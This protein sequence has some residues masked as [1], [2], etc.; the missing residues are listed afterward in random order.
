VLVAYLLIATAAYAVD[1]INKSSTAPPTLQAPGQPAPPARAPAPAPADRSWWRYLDPIEL[2]ADVNGKASVSKLQILFFSI[3]VFGL[4]SYIVM[5]TGVLSDLSPSIL[6]LLGISAVGAAA[7]KATE[8]SR[9]RLDFDNWAWLIRKGWLPPGGLCAVSQAR[10]RDLVTPDGEFSVYNFQM[11]IFSLVVGGALLTTGL[12][13]LASF[14]VPDTLLGVLG[15]SQA[16]Y[17]S[18]KL[19]APPSFKELND[20]VSRLRKLEAD[21]VEAAAI[22]LDPDVTAPQPP[23]PPADLQ[24]AKRRAG[25]VVGGKDRTTYKKYKEE[26]ANTRIMFK[27]IF[28]REV[29]DLQLEPSFV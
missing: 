6:L 26:A 16:V 23:M 20:A 27:S 22:T 19:V 13:D 8:V 28:S 2:C 15:L 3:I 11:L 17:V 25:N 21:F 10:W 29:T 7:S 14:S 9:S 1:R 18:G 5:R 12:N 4:L 24:A